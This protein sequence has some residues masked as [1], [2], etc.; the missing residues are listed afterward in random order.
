MVIRMKIAVL[1]LFLIAAATFSWSSGTVLARESPM[2]AAEPAPAQSVIPGKYIVVL[3]DEVRDSTAVAREH[4]Q[5][6]SAQVL[7]TYQHALNGYTARI[8]DKRLDEVRAEKSVDYVELDQRAYATAQTS[9]WAQR[10]YATAQTLPWGINRVD[11]DRSSTKA[12]NGSGAVSKV[13]VYIIDTGIYQHADLNVVEHVNFARDGKNRDCYGH[14]T[15]VAGIAAARDNDRAVVGVSPGALLTGVKVL[16]CDGEGSHSSVLK[17]I[18]W[19]T[20]NAKKP[21]IANMSLAGP[22]SKT[23]DDA[24]RTSARSGVFYSLAAGDNS[25]S[26]ACK[27]SPARAGAGTNNGIATVAA[28]NKRNVEPSWSDYGRCVDIWAPGAS[29]LSTKMGGGTAAMSGVSQA[30]PH[31][32]GGAAL[33]LSSHAH[34]SPSRVEAALK[35]AAKKPG[36]KSKDGRA[37]LLEYVGRF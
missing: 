5:R 4:A 10:A 35:N 28:T 1:T 24:V 20:A 3:E 26:G 31:V 25:A 17:G 27:F 8:P 23:L 29:I 15:H 21:A 33:Y 7:H 30:S 22:A 34:A 2:P 37:I 16:N 9:P 32:G 13:H 6:H 18:D 14:G 36:T 12:G 11:A 19:V